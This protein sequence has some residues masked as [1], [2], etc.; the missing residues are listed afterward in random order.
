MKRLTALLIGL[1]LAVATPGVASALPG[2]TAPG[3]GSM[4]DY[5]IARGLSQ[6]G[7][8]FSYG[9]GGVGGP[10]HGTG[11]YLHVV[12][13]DASGLTQYAFAG[14]GIKL[15]RSSATQYQVGRKVLPAQAQRGDLIF[16]GPNGTQSVA[17]YLGN[18]QMLE[19]SSAVTV[20]PVRSAEM[21]PYLVRILDS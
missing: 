3:N 17:L 9:G 20:A 7:V 2:A 16:Y 10:T 6:R 1:M 12:G 4:I 5:V 15:P 21:A 14:A 18:Q 13:F 11:R 8:P 19:V